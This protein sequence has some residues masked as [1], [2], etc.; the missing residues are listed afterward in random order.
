[1]DINIFVKNF[2]G[3]KKI[4]VVYYLLYLWLFQSRE[5]Q[6]DIIEPVKPYV[7]FYFPYISGNKGHR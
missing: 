1:M 2:I 6:F 4:G 7:E 3:M 5:E